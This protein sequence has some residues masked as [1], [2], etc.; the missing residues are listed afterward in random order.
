MVMVQWSAFILI[1]S[2]RLFCLSLDFLKAFF[3]ITS[4]Q[5]NKEK[6][7]IDSFSLF[8]CFYAILFESKGFNR[9]SSSLYKIHTTTTAYI[10]SVRKYKEYRVW[11]T[12]SLFKYR[13]IYRYKDD[14]T[15]FI[16][17]VA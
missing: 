13:V 11:V 6:W 15:G 9:K 14:C 4:L 16:L 3:Q 1:Q 7:F 12:L 10:K 2:R 5:V 17:S 8:P